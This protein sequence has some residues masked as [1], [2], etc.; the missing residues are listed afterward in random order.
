M[1]NGNYGL[2]YGFNPQATN[3]YQVQQFNAFK[4]DFG[5]KQEITRVNGENGAKAFYLPPNSSV[6]LLDES[7]P[8]IWLKM[9]DGAGYPTIKAYNIIPIETQT[10]TDVIGLEARIK[11]LENYIN[12]QSNNANVKQ[13]SKNNEQLVS[14][15]G[16]D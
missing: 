7:Q 10:Q 16:N 4:P 12:E 6:L 11:R 14:K 8:I 2:G 9:T 15:C 13:K 1:F 5:I 3:P